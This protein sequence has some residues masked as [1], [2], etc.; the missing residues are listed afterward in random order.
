MKTMNKFPL[1]FTAALA[2][3]PQLWAHA[4][5]P[6]PATHGFWT[7]LLVGTFIAVPFLMGGVLIFRNLT[8]RPVRQEV[9]P[10]S[11]ETPHG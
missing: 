9:E 5:H 3:T 8:S 6:G 10:E 2:A 7:H 1:A 11:K 4:G